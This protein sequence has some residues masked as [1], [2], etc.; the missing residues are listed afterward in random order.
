MN[1]FL[2]DLPELEIGEP[3]RKKK[4]RQKTEP[5]RPPPEDIVVKYIRLKCPRC[6]SYNVPVYDS[7]HLPIRYHRCSKCGLTFKSVEEHV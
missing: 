7:N 6:G 2:D 4:K 3:R 5:L 1:G